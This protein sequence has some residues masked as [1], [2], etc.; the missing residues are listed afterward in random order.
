V[1]DDENLDLE[2][3]KHNITKNDATLFSYGEKNN[4]NY[5]DDFVLSIIRDCSTNSSY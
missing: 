3:S 4:P 2:I 5:I 1:D